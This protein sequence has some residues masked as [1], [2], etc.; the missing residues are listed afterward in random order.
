MITNSYEQY[1]QDHK[2]DLWYYRV[3]DTNIII[4]RINPKEYEYRK[5]KKIYYKFSN[6]RFSSIE[7]ATEIL[8]KK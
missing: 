3:P 5:G 6:M 2:Y 7:E 4:E 8:T 1:I